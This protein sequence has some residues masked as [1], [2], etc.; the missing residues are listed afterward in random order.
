MT[1][2]PADYSA[3]DSPD[4]RAPD[5]EAGDYAGRREL[6]PQHAG[7]RLD[8]VLALLYPDLS[9]SRL[10]ALLKQGH[11]QVFGGDGQVIQASA[12]MK[13]SGDES[14]QVMQ[15]PQTTPIDILAQPIALD[16]IH[17]DE[18]LFVINKPAGLVMHPAA[19]NP[20]GTVQNG[21][22]HLDPALQTIPRSGIVHRLDKDTTGAFVV[23]RTLKAHASLV[24]QL[25]ER[26]MG[27]EYI[28]IAH[29]E[30]LASGSVD[31]PIGRHPRDRL[32]MAVSASG[33]PAVTHFRVT[34]KY[35]AA[36][37]F[38]VKLETGRTHQIRVHMSWLKH[39]LIGDPLYGGRQRIG[40]GFGDSVRNLLENFPRQALHA[41]RLSLIHPATGKQ[42]QWVA[43]IPDDIIQLRE[44]LAAVG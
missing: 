18:H 14:V 8:R 13:V 32:R 39:P 11:L 43:E 22:L 10:Q 44:A 21:L 36:T 31:Q 17:A 41:H 26:T 23:A 20:D 15:L 33:K 42:N 2:D 3:D 6:M 24:Q 35:H 16:V 30:K 28:A 12:S 37:E 25:Q 29:G 7:Q 5:G 34:N 9:R 40:K 4:S 38:A 19:G 27:R 1:D